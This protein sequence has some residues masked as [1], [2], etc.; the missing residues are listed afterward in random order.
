[1]SERFTSRH[2]NTH[3]V[4]PIGRTN[5]QFRVRPFSSLDVRQSEWAEQNNPQGW[6]DTRWTRFSALMKR[7]GAYAQ[8][9]RQLRAQR[10]EWAERRVTELIGDRKV[11]IGYRLQLRREVNRDA[12]DKFPNPDPT[13]AA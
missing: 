12:Y 10:H 6:D 9:V 3:E 1:M 8:E 4:L 11:S 13:G 7:E 5:E 2:G